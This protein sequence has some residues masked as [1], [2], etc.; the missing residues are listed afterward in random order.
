[1]NFLRI[2]SLADR[3]SGGANIVPVKDGKEL[4]CI[5]KLGKDW[6]TGLDAPFGGFAS[7]MIVY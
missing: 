3:T 7:V 2:V 4:T 1:M 6:S 5:P